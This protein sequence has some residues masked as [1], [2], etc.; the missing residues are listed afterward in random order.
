M[1][2]DGG[3]QVK[4]DAVVKINDR[5]ATAVEKYSGNWAQRLLWA[6]IGG[7]LLLLLVLEL[8]N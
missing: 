5:Y 2:A 8:C 4:I 6:V 7:V 1:E 3:L